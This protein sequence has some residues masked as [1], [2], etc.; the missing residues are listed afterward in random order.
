MLP[1]VAETPPLEPVAETESQSK[2]N[3]P[4]QFAVATSE[5]T[6]ILAEDLVFFWGDDDRSN[7]KRTIMCCLSSR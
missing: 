2:A 7:I 6:E 3:A 1:K 5:V 4:R